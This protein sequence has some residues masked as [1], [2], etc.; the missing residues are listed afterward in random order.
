MNRIYIIHAV[1]IIVLSLIQVLVLRNV[2]M[3]SSAGQYIFIDYLSGRIA[4]TTDCLTTIFRFYRSPS[5][6]A[7]S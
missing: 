6:Q 3:S 4:F 2:S 1:R 5:S 7:H